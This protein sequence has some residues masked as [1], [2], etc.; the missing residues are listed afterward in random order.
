MLVYEKLTVHFAVW[1]IHT[2]VG[3]DQ[4]FISSEHMDAQRAIAQD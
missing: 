1:C 4:T 2:Q 3:I